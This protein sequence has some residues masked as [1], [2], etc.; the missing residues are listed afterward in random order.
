[1]SFKNSGP[2][3]G[4]GIIYRSHNSTDMIYQNQNA[5]DL[6][7]KEDVQIA[8]RR[9]RNEER[10]KRILDAKTR[11]FGVDVGAL[12]HQV[13]EKQGIDEMEARR[14][15]FYDAQ[16]NQ[17]ATTLTEAESMRRLEHRE[18]AF[19]L[20]DFRDKQ[21]K[22][23]AEKDAAERGGYREVGPGDPNTPFLKF[24]GEDLEKPYRDQDDKVRQRE[25]LGQQMQ[26]LADKTQYERQEDANYEAEQ[27]RINDVRRQ[28]DIDAAIDRRIRNLDQA[29]YNKHQVALKKSNEESL[30]KWNEQ[31]NKVEIAATLNSKFLNEGVSDMDG[32]S[33]FKGF[34]TP[35]RQRIL[36]EQAAQIAQKNAVRN[37][38]LREEREYDAYQEQVESTIAAANQ[39]KRVMEQHARVTVRQDRQTQA[40]EKTLRYGYLDKVVYQ[41]PVKEEYFQQ[42]GQGCR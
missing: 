40:Q 6:A 14:D 1:M 20:H 10:T 41:N 15:N 22:L 17:F 18:A 11:Q 36:D 33:N 5:T 16:S 3:R 42:F 25:W 27:A 26:M 23:K 38:Q 21:A 13:R 9:A 19:R 35:Q 39:E 34:T 24:A 29:H 12:N 31:S 28:N 30:K 7:S 8:A 2:P 37:R 32:P 4:T